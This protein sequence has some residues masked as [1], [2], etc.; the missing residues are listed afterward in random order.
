MRIGAHVS[1]SEALDRCVD[2]ACEIGSEALQI[3]AC[4]PQSWR[5]VAHDDEAIGT[6]RRRS[7]ECDVRPI[8]VHGIYLVNLCAGDEAHL[9]RS[10]TSLS[11]CLRFCDGVGASGVI[12][13]VGSHK[14]AGF[15]AVL[16][17]IVKAMRKTLDDAPGESWLILEN[18]AGMGNTV[19]ARFGE[20]G[21]ILREL[22]DPRVKVCV[23]TCHAF[24]SGYDIASAE[25]IERA[26]EEFDREIGLAKLVAVHANDSK[27][28]LS[29][30]KDRHENIGE[31]YIG[32][33][34]F[35]TIMAHAA[36]REVP[37]LLEVPG[38]TGKGPDR[39]NVEILKRLRAEV[40]A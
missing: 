37:F 8:F 31:G 32:L 12:F 10:I 24:A 4:A 27:G 39:E 23:D 20:I 38:F 30:G 19:A 6:L 35:R 9:A 33:D 15:D 21:A 26:M 3:F 22:G 29:G 2:R 25:G 16:P 28:P 1:T 40:A 34:G 36:F 17:Q 5:P 7:D 18:S 14:G 11:Q 13:H